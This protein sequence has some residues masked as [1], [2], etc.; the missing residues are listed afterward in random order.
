MAAHGASGVEAIAEAARAALARHDIPATPENY[1]VWY[2]YCA[3][4]DPALVQLLDELIAANRPFTPERNAEI[5]ERFFAD[6]T[7]DPGIEQAGQRLQSVLE[8]IQAVVSESGGDHS[9]YG[10]KLADLSGELAGG[11][12]AEEICA[13]VRALRRE[14]DRILVLNQQLEHR[15]ARSR[16]EIESLRRDLADV[17]RD[18]LTDPLTGIANRKLFDR[19]LGEG[20]RQARETGGA[21]ALVMADIDHF[22]AFNDRFGHRVGDEVL[23]LVARHLRDHVKGR[24]T[25]ARYGGEEFALVLPATTRDG[26]AALA[27]QIRRGLAERHL[28]SRKTDLRYGRITVSL[29]IASYRPG[30]PLDALVQRADRALYAAK[31]RGRNRVCSEADLD[32]SAEAG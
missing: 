8:R 19:R 12:T 6:P 32:P 31:A 11:G 17:R 4:S 3:G 24:D 25:P 9:A 29:G 18:S 20:C 30:E 10:R 23:K 2:A 28:T 26:A 7:R 15:L 1:A 5:Y 22:K 16:R 13:V 14:T 21:L 27:E